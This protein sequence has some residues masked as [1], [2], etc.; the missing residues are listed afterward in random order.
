[1]IHKAPRWNAMDGAGWRPDGVEVTI[2]ALLELVEEAAPGVAAHMERTGR[3]ARLLALELGLSSQLVDLVVRTAR[4]HDVGKLAIPPWVFE[5]SSALTPAE[6]ALKE[7]HSVTG[8]RI[9]ER[10]PS[11]MGLGPLVRA[12]HERWDGTGYP[13]GLKGSTIPLPSRIV[14]VCDAFDAMTDRRAGDDST[15]ITTAIEQ[16]RSASGT[17]FDP[18]IVDPFCDLLETRVGP[19]AKLSC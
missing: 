15:S 12:V 17:R 7:A 19:V 11:L 10:K 8:Q 5:K 18:C 6:H 16:L 13:D 14:A 9:L 1:M 3:L 2:A 4:V